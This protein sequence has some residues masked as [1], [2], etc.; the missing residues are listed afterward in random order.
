MRS[1]VLLVAILSFMS[2]APPV[3]SGLASAVN[4]CINLSGICRRDTCKVI[5][6]IIGGCQ[7]RWKCCRRWWILMPIPTPVIYSDYQEPLK[8]RMK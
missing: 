2:R 3:R 6:D 5:E 4:H 8:G 7:R 1:A